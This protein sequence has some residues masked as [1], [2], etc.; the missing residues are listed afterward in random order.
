MKKKINTKQETEHISL[1]AAMDELRTIAAWFESQ[2]E[3]DLE[4]S[5]LH[6]K[7]GVNIVKHAKMRLKEIENEFDEIKKH[8]DTIN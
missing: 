8:I 1:K 5:I 6:L 2:E 4:Q 3:I 7:N